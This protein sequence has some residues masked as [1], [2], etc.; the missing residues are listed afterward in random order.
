MSLITDATN[1]ATNRRSFLRSTL[2]ASAGAALL[3]SAFSST[4]DAAAA[5]PSF[6]TEDLAV[7]NFALQLE[8]L[9]AQYYSLAT[10]GMTLEQLGFATDGF[11]TQGT[12]TYKS[13]S[14]LV[15]FQ[16]DTIKGAAVEITQD[17]Q[18][19][20]TFL[21]SAISGAGATP[22]A[23]PPIDLLNSFY[24]L[25]SMIGVDNFDPFATELTF[26][27]GAF[28]FEDVG[29]TA[30]RGGSGKI[31][32]KAYL[33][34]AAGILAVEALHAGEI[35]ALL[36]AEGYQAECQAISD[37]RDMVDGDADDDQGIGTADQANIAPTDANGLVYSR[38][39]R[40]VL[41]IVYGAKNATGGLFFPN[42]INTQ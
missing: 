32:N 14:T 17:E 20:V 25:G 7:L 42:G 38:N 12:V 34:A 6:V 10:T 31:S 23:Q 3:P 5:N 1:I 28:I 35:R 24:T 27:L 33:K 15:P 40:R 26:L 39:V 30:Y 18:N 9:E 11:G 21:R 37:A 16:S 29:V 13:T 36:F 4:A 22:A 19:H 2:A 41:D 8:Y